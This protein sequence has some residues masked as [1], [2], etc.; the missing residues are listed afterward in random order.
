MR[1]RSLGAVRSIALLDLLVVWL[2]SVASTRG[3]R[4][5]R[6]RWVGGQ[7]PFALLLSV[8]QRREDLLQIVVVLGRV[9]VTYPSNLG[10]DRVFRHGL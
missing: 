3:D 1:L 10:D 6:P 5:W 9:L 8:L 2:F 7:L 4:F